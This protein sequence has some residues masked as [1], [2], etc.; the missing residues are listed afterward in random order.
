MLALMALA[1]A[2]PA[3]AGC[4]DDDRPATPHSLRANPLGSGGI[5][6]QWSSNAGHYDI[7]IRDAQGRAVPEAPDFVGGAPG[8]NYLEFY[9]L[10]PD[11]E[12]VFTIRA[13]TEGG[14]QGCVSKNASEPVKAR[15]DTA[16]TQDFCHRY[17][18]EAMWQVNALHNMGC[19]HPGNLYTGPWAMNENAHFLFCLEQKRNRKT[20]Y[21][22][23]KKE[24]DRILPQCTLQ[25]EQCKT[26]LQ[27]AVKA[28]KENKD[29][30]CGK[31][32]GRWSEDLGWHYRWCMSVPRSSKEPASE[33]QKREDALA[34]CR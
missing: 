24:R 22:D 2:A 13:R 9:G 28:V 16:D 1:V 6:L 14:T 33:T 15:T 18:K 5:M 26:Y 11:K 29:L 7:T 4:D 30:K 12:Y 3:A 23:A 10:K 25:A 8:K 32:G 20:G 31:T 34:K 27:N 21:E 17:T 19:E